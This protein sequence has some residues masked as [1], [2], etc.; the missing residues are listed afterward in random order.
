MYKETVLFYCALHLA[1]PQ[2]SMKQ[3]CSWRINEILLCLLTYS[4]YILKEEKVTVVC[5][6]S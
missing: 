3:W 4:R 5:V 2:P 1:P 6:D